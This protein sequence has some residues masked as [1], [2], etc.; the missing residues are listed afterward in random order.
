[1]LNRIKSLIVKELLALLRDKKSRS[2]LIFPVFVQLFLFSFAAT[3]EAKN[4]TLGVLNLDRGAAGFELIHR[5]T[6][7]SIFSRVIVFQSP[8]QA[9][10]AI[11]DQ[12]VNAVLWL[13]EDFSRNVADHAK[14]M[15]SLILDGR[16]TNTAQIVQGYA[17]RILTS[18]KSQYLGEADSEPAAIEVRNWFN[19]NLDFLWY[20]V[21]S[22]VCIL[23]T[24][25]TM[26][27][28]GLSVARERELGTFD[29]LLVS[30]LRPIEILA[31]KAIPALLVV[32]IEGGFIILIGVFILHIPFNGSLALLYGALVV[33]LCSIIGIG[34]FISSLAMTQQQA[35]LGT[36]I[37][38]TPAIMLSG[39]ASPIDNMPEWLQTLT[40]ANPVRYFQV[41]IRGIF[42][43]DMTPSMVWS[44]LWPLIVI[45]VVTLSAA[46]WLF[47]H[48]ME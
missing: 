10:E 44:E 17:S 28:T 14:A 3:Q 7:A 13:P 20:T 30:P 22:L 38:I 36:F 46:T 27:V 9:T 24:L 32:T 34:L 18:Y 37:F 43:K 39:F 1:M 21:P 40:L 33:Y 6:A 4:L 19:P 26:L 48:R 47:K 11:N 23:T 8:A 29:Q 42:L 15:A 41:I 12:K 2:V 31:G 45:S 35:V 5:F 16:K 25:I